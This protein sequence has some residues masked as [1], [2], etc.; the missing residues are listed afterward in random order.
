MKKILIET[1]RL[2]LRHFTEQDADAVLDFSR[3]PNVT[4]YTGDQG[5]VQNRADALKVIRT[6][7]LAEYQRHGFARYALIHKGDDRVIG[8]CGVKF[9][10]ELDEIDIGYRML[11]QYWGQGLATEAVQATLD[12][13]R[14]QL[15]IERIVGEVAVQNIASQRV[16]QKCGMKLVKRYQRGEELLLFVYDEPLE[17]L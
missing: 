12:Y 6:V 4:R 10:T 14:A 8:F 1:P 2:Q 13:A 16:L 7:W 5:V 15:G 3:D 17:P 11:P 9:E